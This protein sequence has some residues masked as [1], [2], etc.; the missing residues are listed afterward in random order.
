VIHSK[1]FC[2]GVLLAACALAGFS[3]CRSQAERELGREV[4]LHS[5]LI[6]QVR[7]ASSDARAAK[8]AA[9]QAAACKAPEVCQL[10]QM[11]LQAY[12][13]E[14]KTLAVVK[15][16]KAAVLTGTGNPESGVQLL[17]SSERD[18]EHAH[19]LMVRC[20]EVQGDLERK[21]LAKR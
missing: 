5:H 3:G 9:L 16:V 12:T 20:V 4:S 8:L 13:L 7:D 1:G 2:Y 6:N 19:A 15:Q 18:L 11:C 10:Q 21:Y 17:T 14:A